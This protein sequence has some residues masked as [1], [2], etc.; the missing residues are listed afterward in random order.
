MHSKV[1]LYCKKIFNPLDSSQ[2]TASEYLIGIFKC[3]LETFFFNFVHDLF[4]KAKKKIFVFTVTRPTLIFGRDPMNFYTEFEFLFFNQQQCF[5]YSTVRLLSKLRAKKVDKL[6][7][8]SFYQK[9]RKWNT[10]IGF[11]NRERLSV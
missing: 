8:S 10:G 7:N 4:F 3:S 6:H 2:T 9:F 11:R 5:I 1:G